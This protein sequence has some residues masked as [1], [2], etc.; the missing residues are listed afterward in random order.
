MSGSLTFSG[1]KK[2]VFFIFSGKVEK[3]GFFFFPGKVHEPLTQIILSSL[4]FFKRKS[5]LTCFFFP[6]IFCSI[7]VFFFSWKS[8]QP[9]THSLKNVVFFSGP[10]K[11]NSFFTHSL[12]FGQKFPKRKLFPEKKNSTFG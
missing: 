12:D 8:L 10:G 7:F 3:K 11:K 4:F 2:H 6:P 9:L 5:C 1:K